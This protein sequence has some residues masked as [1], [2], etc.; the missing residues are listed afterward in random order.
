MKSIFPIVLAAGLG[1]LAMLNLSCEDTIFSGSTGPSP[2]RNDSTDV[3]YVRLSLTADTIIYPPGTMPK[4][5]GYVETYNYYDDLLGNAWIRVCVNDSHVT[6]AGADPA[7]QDVTDENGRFDFSVCCVNC[8]GEVVLNVDYMHWNIGPINGATATLLLLPE[9]RQPAYLLTSADPETLYTDYYHPDSTLLR[10]I[11]FDAQDVPIEGLN[12]YGLH[13]WWEQF[14]YQ[15]PQTDA[16]GKNEWLL[17]P[18]FSG[19]HCYQ[20]RAAAIRDS[21]CVT[22]LPWDS[23]HGG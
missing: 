5:A 9:D 14:C 20:V 17:H 15:V 19:R 8:A 3:A 22:V 23:T 11:A 2:E 6:I 7:G 12:V 13:Y 18:G 21:V 4:I 10:V 16:E 1:L